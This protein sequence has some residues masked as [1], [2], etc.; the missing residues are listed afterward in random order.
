MVHPLGSIVAYQKRGWA[1]DQQLDGGF[2]MVFQHHSL[3]ADHREYGKYDHVIYID[4]EAK[5][6]RI[7][8]GT[9]QEAYEA[10]RK[11]AAEAAKE[12]EECLVAQGLAVEIE[13][14]EPDS[15]K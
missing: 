11:I 10:R 1:F 3:K 2:K 7:M 14:P 4:I 13:L 9:G 15:H 6:P 12:I 5:K 8:D